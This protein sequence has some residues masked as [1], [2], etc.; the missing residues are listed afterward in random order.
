MTHASSYYYQHGGGTKTVSRGRSRRRSPRL[1]F[2]GGLLLG[3]S[4]ASVLQA[5]VQEPQER[6]PRDAAALRA[7][8]AADD[9]G[10]RLWVAIEAGVARDAPTR[11]ALTRFIIERVPP[12]RLERKLEGETAST[13]ETLAGFADALEDPAR[14]HDAAD[15]LVRAA[16][17]RSHRLSLQGESGERGAVEELL[18]WMFVDPERFVDQP[19]FRAP[20][21]AILPRALHPEAAPGLR[22]LLLYSINHVPGVDFEASEAIELAWGA[23]LRSSGAREREYR[24]EDALYADDVASPI[25]ASVYSLGSRYSGEEEATAFLEAVHAAAPERPLVVLV[26]L[27]LREKLQ[28]LAPQVSLLETFGREYT[29]W[30]RDPMSLVIRR[31]GGVMVLIRPNVQAARSEDNFLGRELVQTLPDSLD[32]AWGEVA[33]SVAP[34]P[35]HNG[36][37]LLTRRHA[38]VSLHTLEPRI[39]ER[40]GLDRVPVETFGH[41]EGWRRYLAAARDAMVELVSLYGRRVE[42][43]H[44]LPEPSDL[45]RLAG[46]IDRVGGGA[47]FDLDSLVTFLENED[48]SERA[49][50]ADVAGEAKALLAKLTESDL[51]AL[52]DGYGLRPSREPLRQAL[53]TKLATPRARALSDFLDL[54]AEHLTSRGLPVSR[55][56]LLLVPVDLLAKHEGLRH[57]DFLLGWNNVVLERRPG[58]ARAEGFSSLLPTGDALARETFARN[59]YRLDLFPPLTR[60]VILNGGY[61]CASQHL[62]R[63]APLPPIARLDLLWPSIP[64]T[65]VRWRNWPTFT[66]PRGRAPKR[67]G[68]LTPASRSSIAYPNPWRINPNIWVGFHFSRLPQASFSSNL[69]IQKKL[70]R[71]TWRSRIGTGFAAHT[72]GSPDLKMVFCLPM[73]PQSRSY[74]A[75]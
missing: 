15:Y 69:L 54:V 16:R 52:R 42:L 34:V 29:P 64:A 62:R 27:P 32:G 46:T 38:W 14:S 1:A 47:G 21:L 57:E 9:T 60:S 68:W 19:A 43:I 50:V 65:R 31:D 55:L 30:V 5:V 7:W 67:E 3:L 35:F 10:G 20:V 41:P 17:S 39:L 23:A 26:D 51:D 6:L 37:V 12:E 11:R 70:C 4:A 18:T 53:A 61:R 72:R 73:N 49:L 28:T 74:D 25:E 66:T 58:L 75:T 63:T 40:L 71:A 59:G 24:A 48:G 44:P 36:H 13:S 22:D 45:P 2:L 56:P 33:W 8:L